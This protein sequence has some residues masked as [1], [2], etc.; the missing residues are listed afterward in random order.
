MRILNAFMVVVF[1]FAA[2]LQY[3]DPDGL[4]WAALYLGAA[5][6]CALAA[7][8][9]KAWVPPAAVGGVA[10]VWA[11][12]LVPE[13]LGHVRFAQLF[14]AWEMK[15]ARVEVGRELGGLTIVAAWMALLVVLALR[16]AGADPSSG[17]PDR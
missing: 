16:R 7:A 17:A 2:A 6:A 5:L 10:V 3:N 1:A 11:A 14:A 9:R 12:F 13:V 8:E 4:Y 15:N